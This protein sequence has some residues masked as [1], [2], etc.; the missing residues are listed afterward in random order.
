[1]KVWL[2]D[3]RFSPN[4]EPF[5]LPLMMTLPLS[6]IVIPPAAV[7]PEYDVTMSSS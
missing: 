4:S 2:T 3:L 7:Y 6:P 1:M 5:V